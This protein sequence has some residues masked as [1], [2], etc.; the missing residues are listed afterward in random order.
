ME[1]L[2]GTAIVTQVAVIVKDLTETKK[3]CAAF[4]GTEIPETKDSGEFEITRTE[5]LGKPAPKSKCKQAFFSI[6][7]ECTLELI[8]PNGEPSAWQE[9]LDVHG[10][11]VH[12]IAFEVKDMPS[13]IN[14]CEER[15]Y[16]LIQK[17]EYGDG[18]GR[19]AYIDACSDLK[20]MIELLESYS[21]DGN[22][23]A[24]PE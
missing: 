11:G 16:K 18:S 19:Y 22:G 9:F 17:G 6:G 21:P 20:V 23:N 8:M 14:R 15:G 12:H 3:K 10:E 5:Y 2:L 24:K 1:P 7:R 13:V 4:F